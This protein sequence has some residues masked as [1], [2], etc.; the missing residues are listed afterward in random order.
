M[1]ACISIYHFFRRSVHHGKVYICIY[2][3]VCAY[4]YIYV[5]TYIY[6]GYI[7]GYIGMCY[8][9]KGSGFWGWLHRGVNSFLVEHIR[10]E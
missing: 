2:M 3:Y 4:I 5:Y 6:M 9:V 8:E 1:L 7:A 10:S